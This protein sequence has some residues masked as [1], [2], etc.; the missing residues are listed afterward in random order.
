MGKNRQ[1]LKDWKLLSFL[2][3]TL[4]D[5]FVLQSVWIFVLR[6]G[7][8][9]EP[10][11]KE[12]ISLAAAIRAGISSFAWP[13]V[14]RTN[15]RCLKSDSSWTTDDFI[16][17]L[18]SYQSYMKEFSLIFIELRTNFRSCN[19]FLLRFLVISKK[20]KIVSIFKDPMI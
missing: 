3:S 17:I 15:L 4:I 11:L 20:V 10:L 16:Q 13:L 19:R 6:F 8:S 7:D 9:R 1:R 14:M 5:F 2:S 12:R 18:R